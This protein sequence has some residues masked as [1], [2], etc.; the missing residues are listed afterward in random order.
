MPMKLIV[1]TKSIS[2]FLYLFEIIIVQP[3]TGGKVRESDYNYNEK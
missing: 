2:L 1:H 3:E